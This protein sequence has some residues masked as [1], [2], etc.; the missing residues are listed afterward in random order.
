MELVT[1]QSKIYEIRGLKVML[2][3]DLAEMYGTETKYL[4]RSVKNNINRFP[5][6]FMFELTKKEF[7]DLR[8]NFSTSK[9]G[10]TRYMPYAF[11][12]LG[13]SMLSTV[14]NSDVAIEI[15]ISIMRAFV[16]VRQLILNNPTAQIKEINNEIHEL[17]LYIEE[18]LTDYND[19]NEDTRMQIEL[20]NETLAE[21]QGK[22]ALPSR[23]QVGFSA[24]QYT[25][26]DESLQQ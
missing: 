23:K 25:K 12:E 3:F 6:D 21:M 24:P 7:N 2:D 5:S 11:T 22:K 14:L 10:G 20:I 9:R 19:I 8:C 13:V 17:K 18:V 1:I 15:N 4:K 16:V 26:D